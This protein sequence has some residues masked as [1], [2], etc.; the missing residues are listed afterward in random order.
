MTRRRPAISIDDG[1]W[2][3]IEWKK[4]HEECC[5]CGQQH[6]VDYRVVDGKLQ[7]RATNLGRPRK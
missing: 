6:V 2:V 3:T 1:E 4:Q 7:F 5:A